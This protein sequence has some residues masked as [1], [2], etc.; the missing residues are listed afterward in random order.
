MKKNVITA[1]DSG[2]T[3]LRCVGDVLYKDVEI[4]NEINNSSYLGPNLIV[5]GY[6]ISVTG[7]HGA[8]HVSIISDSPWEGRKCVRKM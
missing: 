7:G 6:M 2:V 1:L 3:T 8:P 4:R 5:S